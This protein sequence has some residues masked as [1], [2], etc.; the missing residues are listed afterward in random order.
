V[1]GSG[2][3][4]GVDTGTPLAADEMTGKEAETWIVEE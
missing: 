4:A 1:G 2:T 3:D